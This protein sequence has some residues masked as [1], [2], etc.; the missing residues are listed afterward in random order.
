MFGRYTFQYLVWISHRQTPNPRDILQALED[1]QKY[2]KLLKVHKQP[3]G[4]WW[5]R[6]TVLTTAMHP[7]QPIPVLRK[8]LTQERKAANP[9]VANI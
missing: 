7:T 3:S 8:H 1:R 4:Y 6:L 2:P 9:P 5:N